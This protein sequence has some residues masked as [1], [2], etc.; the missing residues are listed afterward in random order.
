[1][2]RGRYGRVRTAPDGQRIAL[3]S[4]DNGDAIIWTYELAGTGPLQRLTFEGRNQFPVWAPDGERIAFQS[5]RGGDA[6]IWAQRVDGTGNAQRLT[7]A[8]GGEAHIP[9]DWSPDGQ[10]LAVA[11]VR[12]GLYSP[13]LLSLRDGMLTPLGST[14]SRDP[15][16]ASFSSDG[17][18]IAYH[19]SPPDVSPTSSSA[20]VFVEPIPPNGARYQAPKMAR[21]FQ[22]LWSQEGSDLYYIPSAASSHIARVPV[23]AER[24]L[25]FG[26]PTLLP[27]DVGA[28]RLAGQTRA[29]DGLPGGRFI[30]LA[31][32]GA[33]AL[34]SD[35]HVRVVVNWFV[36]LERLVPTE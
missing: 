8:D 16:S 18:W 19:L 34:P 31:D 35:P 13:T 12:D 17:R 15:T 28:Q 7:T 26:T 32:D 14:V 6:A 5:T 10:L 30:G 21:D 36:E 27:F 11:V 4:D 23:A 20:G 24:G 9:E 25:S 2:P 3:D 33:P 1:V 29:F 22:P